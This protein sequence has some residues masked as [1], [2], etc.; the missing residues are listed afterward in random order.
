[1]LKLISILL[2]FFSIQANASNLGKIEIDKIYGMKIPVSISKIGQSE[3]ESKEADSVLSQVSEIVKTDLQTTVD[4]DF[5]GNMDHETDLKTIDIPKYDYENILFDI[6]I[7][8]APKSIETGDYYIEIKVYNIKT[9][10][11]LTEKRYTFNIKN[12]RKTG[13]VATDISYYAITGKPGYFQ[14]KIFFTS[15]DIVKNKNS[16]TS[17]YVIDQDGFGERLILAGGLLNNPVMDFKNLALFYTDTTSGTSVLKAMNVLSG[18]PIKISDLYSSLSW[19]QFATSP[20]M[21]NNGKCI[22]YVDS[23]GG[24]GVDSGSSIKMSFINGSSTI[25]NDEICTSPS[26]SP[27]DREIVFEA[28]ERGYRNIYKIGVSKVAQIQTLVVGNDGVYAEPKWSPDGEWIVFTKLRNRLFHVGIVRPDGTEEQI[29]YSGYM[30]E[31]PIWMPNSDAL[32]FSYKKSL[33]SK[34]EL[35]MIDLSGRDIRKI[36]TTLGA[37]SPFIWTIR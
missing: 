28:R 1:M 29:L 30:I 19:Q 5:K 32:L 13:H 7:N 37:V 35:R 18:K 27:N 20:T 11:I 17:L 36:K 26:L 3:Y 6:N 21:C 2:C 10:E 33:T 24:N 8:V 12:I 4:I 25:L 16:K 9:N 34:S 31:N 14:S 23:K 15:N 22:V